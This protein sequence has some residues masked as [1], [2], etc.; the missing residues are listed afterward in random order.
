MALDEDHFGRGAEIRHPAQ[1]V[2]DVAPLVARRDHDRQ[3]RPLAERPASG[4]STATVANESQRSPGNAGIT[5]LSSEPRPK[6]CQGTYA[7]GRKRTSSNPA[8]VRA[9]EIGLGHERDD[10]RALPEPE[11]IGQPE[12]P[13]EV[14]VVERDDNAPGPFQ[15]RP[16]GFEQPLD[17][18]RVIEISV[19]EEHVDA[20]R[21]RP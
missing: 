2:F 10:R 19:E 12:Q 6:K 18:G 16:H 15:L 17:I 8:S 3:R 21:F 5:T 11:P 7:T 1:R 9:A 4:L 13:G 20:I 14:P